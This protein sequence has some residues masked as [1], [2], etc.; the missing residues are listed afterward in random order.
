MNDFIAQLQASLPRDFFAD[1][2]VM[3]LMPNLGNAA[4]R[5]KL[6]REQAKGRVL[7]LMRGVYA[8]HEPY[9]RTGL[10]LFQIANHLAA[11]SYVS[12]ESALSYYGLI[13]EG[14][15]TTTS[16]TTQR[17]KVVGTPIGLFTF[18]HLPLLLF[19]EGFVQEIQGAHHF[20][21]ANPVKALLDTVYVQRRVYANLEQLKSD[22]RLN[23]ETMAKC[24]HTFTNRELDHYRHTFPRSERISRLIDLLIW[25]LK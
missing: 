14:V 18:T 21:I 16:V 17:S 24:L 7:R 9:R 19:R 20:L 1:D 4:R 3:L 22:L 8:I 23:L 10:N 25:E 6:T 2:E 5:N 11:T 12:L 15:V 13:P